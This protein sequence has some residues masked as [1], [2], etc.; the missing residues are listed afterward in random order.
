MGINK[1]IRYSSSD[2]ISEFGV[3]LNGQLIDK[4][5]CF[6]YLN[7]CGAMRCDAETEARCRVK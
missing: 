4:V 5:Q 3:V 2:D 6:R 7:S 1:G